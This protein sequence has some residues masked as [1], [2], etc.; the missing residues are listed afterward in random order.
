[1]VGRMVVDSSNLAP[2]ETAGLL[3]MAK[4]KRKIDW[5]A[6]Q[7]D[8]AKGIG[9]SRLAALHGLDRSQIRKAKKRF[10][11]P[12]SPRVIGGSEGN[13]PLPPA[14][15]ENIKPRAPEEQSLAPLNEAQQAVVDD[16][17]RQMVDLRKTAF[18]KH[19][20]ALDEVAQIRER[21]IELITD[22]MSGD[23]VRME[24]VGPI[25]FPQ[26]GDSLSVMIRTAIL[27]T[28]MKQRLERDILGMNST[29]PEQP[30]E[31]SIAITH[32]QVVIAATEL[33][34]DELLAVRNAVAKLASKRPD[35]T[36]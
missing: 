1:M 29:K 21:L 23:P 31:Q 35:S 33:S 22:W 3:L 7:A 11:W 2:P 24:K 30:V 34:A 32:N 19:L 12:D 20:S 13:T 10:G 36:S 26:K 9:V 8:Y 28:E 25:L 17:V 6:I 5:V 14:I 4:P 15:T 27:A 18:F 16:M